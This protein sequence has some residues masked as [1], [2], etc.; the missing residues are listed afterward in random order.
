MMKVQQKVSGC[1]RDPAGADQFC[2]V[3]GYI[4][5]AR[6]QGH[7]ALTALHQVFLGSPLALAPQPSE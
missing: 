3:R 5:T 2:R 4:S 6:K 1:F 7:Q